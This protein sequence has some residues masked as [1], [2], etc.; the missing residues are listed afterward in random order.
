MNLNKPSGLRN[1]ALWTAIG[2]SRT[3][4]PERR[5]NLAF[6]SRGGHVLVVVPGYAPCNFWVLARLEY[7]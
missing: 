2:R 5:M 6:L 4:T 7:H 1:R 3:L